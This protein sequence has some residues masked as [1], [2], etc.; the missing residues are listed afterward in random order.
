MSMTLEQAIKGHNLSQT[1]IAKKAG[2][3]RPNLN[4]YISGDKPYT[5]AMRLRI[6][7]AIRTIYKGFDGVEVGV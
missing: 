5:E 6:Q 2:I 1:E 3:S 4:R 7:D